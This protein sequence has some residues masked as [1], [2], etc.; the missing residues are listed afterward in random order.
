MNKRLLGILRSSFVF[1]VG[2]IVCIQAAHAAKS[3]GP[4]T[5]LASYVSFVQKSHKAPFDRDGSV[6]P[7]AGAQALAKRQAEVRAARASAPV[8]TNYKNVQVTQDR[9][10]WPK[11]EIAAAADP[12]SPGGWVVMSNDFRENYDKMFFHVS[13]DNGQTWTDDSM[14]GGSD[15]FT[16]FIPSTFQS[17]PGL[18][19]DSSTNSY[20]STLTGNLIIDFNAGYENL[21]TEIDIA[22]GFANGTYANLLPTP[23]DVQ[24]CNGLF[25]AFSCDISLDKPF[26]TTDSGAGSPNNGT[27][28]VYY[29]LFCNSPASGFCQ[30]GTAKIT[31]GSSAIVV[32]QSPGPGQQFSAP[33]LVSGSFK[34]TQFSS[35]VIDSAGVPHIFFDDFTSSPTVNMWEATLVGSTWV[36]A[37]KPIVSFVYNGLRNSNWGFRDFG[38]VAPGCTIHGVTAY[39]A[40]TANQIG[41]GKLEASP[42]VYLVAVNAHTAAV[43]HV[44]RVNSDPFN[45]QKHHFFPW[46]AATPNGSVYVGWYDD[47]NDRFN[48][49]V[50]YFVGKSVDGGKT[51]PVQKA[52]TDVNFNPCNGFP[53]CGFFGDYTQLVSGPDG[54][55]HAAWSDTRDGASMQIWS[56]VITW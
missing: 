7:P 24:P 11:A 20:L 12:T 48:T 36:V 25:T 23:I 32:S 4:F 34:N 10:P 31:A 13:T 17:D 41:S 43:S 26:V 55:I 2:T 46:A 54:I 52:V 47:R 51:F 50:D 21:D 5:D 30:D 18:S 8:I 9:N 3:V 37:S 38:S 19:F 42:S 27:T 28:Y 44:T 1:S 56:Q 22:Q 40:F 49:K 14:V 53:G 45:D 35:M 29:T 33:A 6:L 15:P 16:G 39:C